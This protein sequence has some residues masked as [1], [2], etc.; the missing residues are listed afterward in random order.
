MLRKYL[1]KKENS[2]LSNHEVLKLVGGKANMIIYSDIHKYTNI[3][4]ILGQHKACFLLYE[5][6]KDYGHWC[7]LYMINDVIYFFD[8]YGFV[9]DDELGF[10]HKKFREESKQNYQYLTKLL[11][12]AKKKVEYNQYRLQSFNEDIATC[13]YHCVTRLNYKY[14]SIDKY[15]DILMEYYPEVTPD[16][17]VVLI[18]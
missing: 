15:A 9:P 3:Y 12:D 8:S 10:I 1:K 13:G 7:C 4:Q 11:Y 6:Q 18:N 2:P 16:D 14:I 17:I 5:T